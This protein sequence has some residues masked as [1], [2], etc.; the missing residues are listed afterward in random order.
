MPCDYSNGPCREKVHLQRHR[1]VRE[2]LRAS[3]GASA[4]LR[5]VE[6]LPDREA[7]E[8]LVGEPWAL[9]RL[10][11]AVFGVSAVLTLLA[12]LGLVFV[13]LWLG[14]GWV[15]LQIVLILTMFGAPLLAIILGYSLIERRQEQKNQERAISQYAAQLQQTEALEPLLCYLAQPSLAG[16]TRERCW[17]AAR[18]LLSRLPE[19]QARVLS[20]DVRQVLVALLEGKLLTPAQVN[21]YDKSAILLAL[22]AHRDKKTGT[23]LRQLSTHPSLGEVAQSLLDEE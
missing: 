5:Q 17:A 22:S 19:N 20:T 9:S 11:Q 14:R 10:S 6:N 12:W 3:D 1:D 18:R 8:A 7:L 21:D 15:G 16:A 4:A 2:A 23:L 13:K